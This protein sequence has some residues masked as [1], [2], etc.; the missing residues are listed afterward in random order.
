MTNKTLPIPQ[1]R[2]RSSE[3]NVP[4]ENLKLTKLQKN[5]REWKSIPSL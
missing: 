4:T 5:E 3:I 1:Q 2:K